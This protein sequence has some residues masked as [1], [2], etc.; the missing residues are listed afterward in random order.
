MP[1][2]LLCPHPPEAQGQP[3]P[4]IRLC[5]H[6]RQGGQKFFHK[7][8]PTT[9]FQ[10]ASPE[11]AT[12]GLVDGRCSVDAERN[13]RA[14]LPGGEITSPTGHNGIRGVRFCNPS[15]QHAPWPRHCTNTTNGLTHESQRDD[16]TP[17]RWEGWTDHTRCIQEPDS[18][19][20]KPA[21]GTPWLLKPP[22]ALHSSLHSLG[23]GAW[24]QE[25]R[26]CIESYH[27]V[28]RDWRCQPQTSLPEPTATHFVTRTLWW[29]TP[30][31]GRKGKQIIEASAPMPRE[32]GCHPGFSLLTSD[33][34]VH[35]DVVHP[36]GEG[37]GLPRAPHPG[38][39]GHA[40]ALPPPAS[41]PGPALPVSDLSLLS[42]NHGALGPL[43]GK[44]WESETVG[45]LPVPGTQD[46][47]PHSCAGKMSSEGREGRAD[48]DM[49]GG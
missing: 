10:S 49:G 43:P 22:A 24:P 2:F 48:E 34:G 1:Q 9:S 42:P 37:L 16:Q 36:T 25:H 23:A 38:L 31:R 27:D 28:S 18:Q 4:T 35:V 14:G 17:G 6:T 13:K 7:C 47:T 30:K 39:P 46:P 32:A 33:A 3:R 20:D 41:G 19:G 45:P 44:A 15:T 12:H 26:P 40:V 11:E 29:A 21:T 5:L 8:G